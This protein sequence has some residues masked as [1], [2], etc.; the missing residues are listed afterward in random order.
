MG[1]RFRL[2]G[3]HRYKI[4]PVLKRETDPL[5]ALIAK[6]FGNGEQGAMYIPQPQVLG[7]QVLFQDAAGTTPVTAD[8]DP[9]GLMLDVSQGLERGDNLLPQ[10][11]FA[12][13]TEGWLPQSGWS[14]ADGAF[15]SHTGTSLLSP[16]SGT[17]GRTYELRVVASAETA[18]PMSIWFGPT[19]DSQVARVT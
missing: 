6:L 14:F 17:A 10:S 19:A 2:K 9:V 11:S 7:Q 4:P 8:G 1:N 16:F 12:D 5:R 3:F 13:G 18:G 15:T